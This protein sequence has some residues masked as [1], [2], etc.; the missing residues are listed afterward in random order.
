MWVFT[1]SSAFLI[2]HIICF[3]ACLRICI[4]VIRTTQLLNKTNSCFVFLKIRAKNVCTN[5]QEIQKNQWA[6]YGGCSALGSRACTIRWYVLI[7]VLTYTITW[8]KMSLDNES[9]NQN[10]TF[11]THTNKR[12]NIENVKNKRQ[13]PNCG[14]GLKKT[15]TVSN[16][17]TLHIGKHFLKILRNCRKRKAQKTFALLWCLFFWK[18]DASIHFQRLYSH[19]AS[20]FFLYART[21]TTCNNKNHWANKNT[22]AFFYTWIY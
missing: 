8:Y 14:S 11:A 4:T 17:F 18:Y 9:D 21:T 15:E 19:T 13:P 3:G 2:I 22:A 5:I 12:C 16:K 7:S 1:S 20:Y 10:S 6:A